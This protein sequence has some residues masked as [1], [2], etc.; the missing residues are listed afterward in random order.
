MLSD[1]PHITVSVQSPDGTTNIFEGM[2]LEFECDIEAHP[3][4]TRIGWLL[5][6]EQVTEDDRHIIE[7]NWMKPD[8]HIIGVTR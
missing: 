8:L 3:N 4:I 5:D 7:E 6:G 1:A 2:T